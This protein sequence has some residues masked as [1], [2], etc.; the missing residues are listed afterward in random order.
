MLLFFFLL[1]KYCLFI[2]IFFLS[3]RSL[4][5]C[6]KEGVKPRDLVRLKQE[7]IVSI[8]LNN[9]VP[10]G[11]TLEKLQVHLEEKR[12]KLVRRLQ[13][14]RTQMVEEKEYLDKVNRIV[15]N[16]KNKLSFLIIFGKFSYLNFK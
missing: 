10:D 14:I 12:Q 4:A 3:P 5:A 2:C 15:S 13:I 7:Q 16:N 1:F 11:L 9:K 6:Q 8:F